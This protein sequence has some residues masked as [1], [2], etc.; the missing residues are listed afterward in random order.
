MADQAHILAGEGDRFA[1]RWQVV[2][3][4]YDGDGRFL[5]K[6]FQ[7]RHL[8]L[9]AGGYTLRQLCRPEP[10]LQGHGM[11][12]FA[13]EFV[14]RLAKNGKHRCYLGPDVLGGA[15]AF[16]RYMLG[17]GVW[18]RFGYNFRSWSFSL[19]ADRQLTGGVFLRGGTPIARIFGLATSAD[20]SLHGAFDPEQ[21]YV[22]GGC[23][24]KG[25]TAILREQDEEPEILA[26]ERTPGLDQAWHDLWPG[27]EESLA[28]K[29]CGKDWLM[30]RHGKECGT[31]ASF[32]PMFVYELFGDDGA[33]STG[34]EVHDPWESRVLGIKKSEKWG[35]AL[36]YQGYDL[37]P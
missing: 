10:Q 25:E 4:V 3:Y 30:T 20:S 32:G 31:A 37:R 26:M 17:Q 16:S 14:F 2:E 23:A 12:A 24:L 22:P 34:I 7:E 18:P 27:E 28:L 9:E 33:R 29:P 36:C 11:A 13:G 21:R 15:T 6:V 35:R 5:G 8:S 1:G 19:G